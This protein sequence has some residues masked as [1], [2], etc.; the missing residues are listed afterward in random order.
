MAQY[1][2]PS[3]LSGL[4][5]ESYGDDVMNLVPEVAKLVKMI[6]FVSRDKE[7]GNKYHQPVIVASEQGV[8]YAAADAGAFALEDSVSMTMQDAQVQGSQMLLRSA[9]S[10]DS[11]ARASNSKKAFVKSTELLVE[12]MMESL[13]KRLEVCLLHGH[14]GI[15]EIAIGDFDETSGGATTATFVLTDASFAAG[16]WSGIEGAKLVFYSDSDDTIQ[17]GKN[18]N[19][20][21]DTDTNII[22]TAVDVDTK[23]ISVS[24]SAAAIEDINDISASKALRVYFKGSVQGSESTFQRNEMAGLRKIITNTGTLFN[25]SAASY[26]LWKGNSVSVSGQ[27][28]MGKLLS[29][30][31]KAVNRGLA[32]KV[33]VAVNPD[34]WANLASDLAAL[35]RFDGSYDKKKGENGFESLVYH[36]QNGEIE[37]I[38]HNL[39]K[40]AECYIFPPKRCKRI[41]AQE[42]SFKT[43]GRE[44]EIFLHLPSNAGFELRVYS[45]QALFVETPAR[46]IYVS[47]FT[48]A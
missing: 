11:A 32:E 42:I 12:N 33:V 30:I 21:S 26:N 2:T 25:I 27:L 47:G 37:I 3:Q 29:S 48:N 24:G 43:P 41:G 46:C 15:G 45:D 20:N 23:T 40:A 8:T 10:Y 19:A 5:K 39:V 6:P 17:A 7:L 4:F 35:R 31:S 44:D 1:V 34:T 9:I 18:I 14:K 22:V 36:G 28:T 16:I 38:S 13:T